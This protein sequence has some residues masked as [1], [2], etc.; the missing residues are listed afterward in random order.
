MK[1]I[2]TVKDGRKKAERVILNFFNLIGTN[3][4]PMHL[5]TCRRFK[6]IEYC[7]FAPTFI[8]ICSKKGLVLPF[9]TIYGDEDQ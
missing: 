2:E 9:I 5:E 6:G 3:L 4:T 1:K 8:I 7:S